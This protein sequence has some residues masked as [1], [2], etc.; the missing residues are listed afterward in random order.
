MRRPLHG[1]SLGLLALAALPARGQ[2]P[3]ARLDLEALGAL[4]GQAVDRVS[5]P[6]AMPVMGGPDCRGYRIQGVGVVFVLPPRALHS[7]GSLV[8]LQEHSVGRSSRVPPPQPLDF[9]TDRQIALI[10]AQA[11]E[12]TREAAR[13]RQDAERAL[14]QVSLQIRT[15]LAPTARPGAPVSPASVPQGPTE[16]GGTPGAP[17]APEG[18]A[19]PSAPSAPRPPAAPRAPTPPMPAAAPRPVDAPLPPAPP[20][21]YW[22]ESPGDEDDDRSPDAIVA[23]VKEVVTRVIVGHGSKLRLLR[24]EEQLITAV[25]FVDGLLFGGATRPERT[26]VVRVTKRDLDERQAG[27]LSAEDLRKRIQY[28]EY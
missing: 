7:G 15:R 18:P 3:D 24:P 22:F 28:V 13:A 12:L 11:D 27:N 26:L 17:P 8:L 5:H 19:A 16:T 4:L 9:E 14:E 21:S 20:W 23:E 1:L 6:G 10:E 25:D 2:G